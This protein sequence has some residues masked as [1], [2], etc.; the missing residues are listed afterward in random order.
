MFEK[1]KKVYKAD[2]EKWYKEN[3]AYRQRVAADQD[4]LKDRKSTR[5][6]SSH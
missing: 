3:E 1:Y 6:N 5:L 2:Y 4:R